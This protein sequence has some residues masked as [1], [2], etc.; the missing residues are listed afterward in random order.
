MSGNAEV[1]G[2]AWNARVDAP[3][4]QSLFPQTD[5]VVSSVLSHDL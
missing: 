3:E 2:P 4:L 5:R 1:Q